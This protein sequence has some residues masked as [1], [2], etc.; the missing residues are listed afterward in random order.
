MWENKYFYEG[1]LISTKENREYISSEAMLEKARQEGRILEGIVKMCDSQTLEMHIDLCGIDA[2]IPKEESVYGVPIKDIAI[3][4]RVGKPVAFKILE[5][6]KNEKGKSYAILSRKEAQRECMENYLL[7]LVPGDIIPAK[8]TH[9]EPFGAFVDVGCGVASLLCIDS[10]SVSRISNPRDRFSPREELD[11]IVKSIDYETGRIYVSTKEL[12]G[13]WEE[14]ASNFKV[15]QTVS[16]IVRSVES[17]GI[18]VELAPNLAGLAELKEGV[19]QGDACSVYI[20]SIMPEKMKI[21]L[22]II[23][24]HEAEL[25]TRGK[26]KFFLDTE[27]IKHID[28]WKYSPDNCERV[29]ETNFSEI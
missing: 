28:Y 18:F 4:T 10:I 27:N 11:V 22:V 8:I 13:T 16:G 9:F 25:S 26:E 15:G 7:D 24:T 12:F 17:Y 14:N 2:V 3:I 20:K 5:I 6:G 1:K 29:V 23:D 21:K 19:F